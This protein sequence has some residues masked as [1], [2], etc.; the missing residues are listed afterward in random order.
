M[1][2]KWILGISLAAMSVAA[3]VNAGDAAAGQTKAAVCAGCHGADGNSMVPTFPS[4]AG[5][6]PEYIVK[7]LSEFKAGDRYDPSMSPMAMPLSE[8]DMHDLAAYFS[9]QSRKG[10][11]AA[12]DK[13]DLGERLYRGG[14]AAKGLVACTACHGPT[15]AG[16]ASAKYPSI[17]GQSAV[18][19]EK[20][21]KD[22]AAG[23]RAND[24][25]RMMREIAAKMSADE[26][27]AV[28]Q[29]MQGLY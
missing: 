28:A 4:L 10:G 7:Q 27:A 8:E 20:Q 22:F 15:G 29:Y 6:H 13:I 3:P 24:P 1:M 12:A 16:I 19:I 25:N 17:A 11:E 21:L 18:Y 5:Q 23:N 9:A 26:M 14:N 2:N